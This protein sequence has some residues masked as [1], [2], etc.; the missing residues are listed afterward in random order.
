MYVGRTGRSLA[1][2]VAEHVPRLIFSES[3]CPPWSIR[4]PSSTITRHLQVC[5]ADI[6]NARN[7]FRILFRS[8]CATRLRVLEALAIKY[9]KPDLYVCPKRFCLFVGFTLVVIVLLLPLFPF[10]SIVS[11]STLTALCFLSI[12]SRHAHVSDLSLCFSRFIVSSM[13]PDE[14]RTKG[15]AINVSKFTCSNFLFSKFSKRLPSSTIVK[16]NLN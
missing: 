3:R 10:T 5:S 2:R 16:I 6:S 1:E 9:F 14:S 13:L 7:S 15:L 11:S 8:H 4:I 12:S